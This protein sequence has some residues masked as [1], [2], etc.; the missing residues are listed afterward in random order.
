LPPRVYHTKEHNYSA[1]E[2]PDQS[3]SPRPKLLSAKPVLVRPASRQ[4]FPLNSEAARQNTDDDHEDTGGSEDCHVQEIAHKPRALS[5]ESKV[6]SNL[7][8]ISGQLHR[9][10]KLQTSQ[11]IQESINPGSVAQLAEEAALNGPFRTKFIMPAPTDA[12]GMTDWGTMVTNDK[13]AREIKAEAGH[14][15]IRAVTGNSADEL[16][17]RDGSLFFSGGAALAYIET[18]P[19]ETGDIKV[20]SVER[21]VKVYQS[22]I[23]DALKLENEIQRRLRLNNPAGT[24]A[25]RQSVLMGNAVSRV[26]SPSNLSRAAGASYSSIRQLSRQEH[27][28][29]SKQV[30]DN[31]VNLD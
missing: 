3:C 11:A 27:A 22:S 21:S 17:T 28:K 2:H 13:L 14:G 5:D 18:S 4:A 24:H 26:A 1:V 15:V 31:F 23:T 30:Y 19:V 25:W 16:E 29:H 20:F 10:R 9:A 8:T 7:E 12:S 6:A